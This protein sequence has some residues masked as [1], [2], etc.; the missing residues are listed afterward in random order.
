MAKTYYFKFGSGDPSDYTG[1]SPTLVIFSAFGVTALT[2]PGI[3]ETPAGSGLYQM[4]YSPTL[5]IVFKLDGGAALASSVRYICDA[6]DPIQAVDEK[7]GFSTDSF[8]STSIDPSTVFGYL[9]RNQEFQE[10][11]A[12][13]TKATGVWQVYSRGS[14]TLIAEKDLANNTS[15]ATK[16]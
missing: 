5:P 14:S 16:T 15:S 9:K 4:Q 3:T 13:Y 12:T 7:L 11:N 10:G 1:L 2:A 8:G 6:L